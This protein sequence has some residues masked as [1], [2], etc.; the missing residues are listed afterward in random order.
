MIAG[1]FALAALAAGAALVEP[2]TTDE[3]LC[4]LR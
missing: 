2:K 1:A 4:N 3:V